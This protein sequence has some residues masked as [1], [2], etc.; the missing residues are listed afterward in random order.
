MEPQGPPVL[1]QVRTP[2]RPPPP[3]GPALQG[4]LGSHRLSAVHGDRLSVID[5]GQ[6]HSPSAAAW[7]CCSARR[8]LGPLRPF[9]CPLRGH[10]WEQAEVTTWGQFA[11]LSWGRRPVCEQLGITGREPDVSQLSE[12]ACIT[13]TGLLPQP[14]STSHGSDRWSCPLRPPRG[15]LWGAAAGQREQGGPFTSP[16]CL[17]Q[18]AHGACGITA[19]S[20][21]GHQATSPGL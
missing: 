18:R 8:L 6:S 7:P 13:G 5:V 3:P 9:P 19:P 11:C 14:W 20:L 15:A 1:G 17:F 21:V 10:L 4:V 16:I 12:D 2:L